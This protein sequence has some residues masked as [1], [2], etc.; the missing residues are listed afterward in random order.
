MMDVKLFEEWI[1]DRPQIIKDLAKKLPPWDR[2]ELRQTGQH[3]SLVSY[4]ENNTVTI[5]VDGHREPNLDAVNKVMP[6][7]VFGI[8]PDDLKVI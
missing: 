4:S 1:A 6:I 2:Y 5:R 3:C 7:T 8:R